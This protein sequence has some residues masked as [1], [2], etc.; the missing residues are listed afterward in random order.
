VPQP[1]Q[2]SGEHVDLSPRVVQST[3]VTGSP[4]GAV[5]TI[6]ATSPALG[7][8]AAALGV[9]ILAT[10]TY[11]VGTSGVSAIYRIRRTNAA[12]TAI[13]TSGANTVAAGNLVTATIIGL[14]TGPTLPGQVYVATL[15]IGSGAAAST[16]SAVPIVAVAI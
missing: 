8:L 6:V 15:T 3:A 14:D 10:L 7:D 11:T 2:V 16:V 9:L 4:A 1:I 5:E 13:F 12:G